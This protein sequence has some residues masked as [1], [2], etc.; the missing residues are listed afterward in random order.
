[1]KY[2]QRVLYPELA[3]ILFLVILKRNHPIM[4][5]G[6]VIRGHAPIV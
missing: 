3:F 2:T 4:L 6:V 1:M 5:N